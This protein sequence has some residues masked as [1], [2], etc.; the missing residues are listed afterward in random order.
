M[1]E[2]PQQG[3]QQEPAPRPLLELGNGQWPQATLQ[4][5]RRMWEAFLKAPTAPQE[6]GDAAPA[7]T[8]C[9]VV[10]QQGTLRL[11]RYGNQTDSNCAE[12]VLVCFSLVN[13]P[14]ILDLQADRSVIRRL[15]DAGLDVYLIDWGIPTPADRTLQICDYVCGF[16]KQVADFVCTHAGSPRLHLLGY[17]MGGTMSAMYASLFAEQIRSLTLMAAPIDFA[18]DEGLLNLWTNEQYFDVD[19]LIDRYGNCPAGFLQ[20]S[21]QMMKPVQNFYEKYVSF[22]ERM[23]DDR[24][25]DNFVAMERWINDNIPVAGETFRE[26]VKLLYQQNLLVQGK[27]HLNE[28]RVDLRNITCPLLMLV[29]QLDHLVPPSST[30]NLRHHVRSQQIQE[31]SIDAGHIGL[32]VSSKAHQRLWPDAAGWIADH[33]TARQ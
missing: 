20:A 21:F 18:G 23:Y 7:V 5:A 26:F 2:R 32:A 28:Q 16:M 6:S 10:Y 4:D 33:S 15:L 30:L 8:P 14:Y 13:R 3:E 25:M 24:F 12:P 22:F 29:A 19:A 27:M 17:C 31:M 11:L 9:D 1:A